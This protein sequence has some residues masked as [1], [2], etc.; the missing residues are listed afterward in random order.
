M[1]RLTRSYNGG[2][3]PDMEW[4]ENQARK[5]PH[6]VRKVNKIRNNYYVITGVDINATFNLEIKLY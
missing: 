1:Y 3:T 2:R 4:I 6:D 5:G